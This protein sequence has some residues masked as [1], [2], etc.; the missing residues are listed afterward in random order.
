[1]NDRGTGLQLADIYDAPLPDSDNE[2]TLPSIHIAE[3]PWRLPLVAWWR[4]V[5]GLLTLEGSQS[6]WSECD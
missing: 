6:S 3:A 1:M 4:T 5:L 2:P